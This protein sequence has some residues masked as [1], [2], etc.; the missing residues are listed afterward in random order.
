MEYPESLVF[1]CV[2]WNIITYGYITRKGGI[3]IL[4]HAI[5]RTVASATLIDN[6]FTNNL[7][8]SIVGGNIVTDITD[9]FSQACMI[10][11]QQQLEFL[12]N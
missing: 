3:T 5:E 6:I 8:N 12:L 4:Y 1:P 2:S 9:H 7:E 11:T 10:L